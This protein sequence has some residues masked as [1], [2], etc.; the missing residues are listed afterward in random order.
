[1]KE[2]LAS[3]KYLTKR[4]AESLTELDPNTQNSEEGFAFVRKMYK[5]RG[6]KPK[7][8]KPSFPNTS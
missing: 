5:V 1:M 4:M 2:E 3:S 8:N 7:E 6:V